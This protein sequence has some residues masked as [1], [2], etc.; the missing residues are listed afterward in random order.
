[1]YKLV[2]GCFVI[3]GAL[4]DLG[5]TPQAITSDT[6]QGQK[7]ATE[8]ARRIDQHIARGYADRKVTP[9]QPADD[10]EFL[11]RVFLD[12]TGRIPPVSE[13]HR[14]LKST[15]PNKRA[16]LIEDLLS[17]HNYSNHFAIIWRHAILPAGN[18]NQ[19][20]FLAN[21]IKSW[22]KRK[23]RD[24]IPYNRI[25]KELLT[26]N[27]ATAG[28]MVMQNG[29]G[30]DLG[31]QAYYQ[32]NEFKP[33]N[34]AASSSRLFLGVRLECA[35]C[36]DHPFARWKR[37]QFWEMAAFYVESQPNQPQQGRAMETAMLRDGKR[38]IAIPGTSKVVQAR[39]LNGMEPN[40]NSSPSSTTVLA[41]W[42]TSDSNSFFSRALVNRYWAHFFG[43]G[44]I[45][46]IDE[47]ENEDNPASHPELLQELAD[48]FVKSNYDLKFLIRA[49]VNSQTYQ[50]ASVAGR[51]EQEDPRAFARMALKGLSGEQLFD[52]LCQATGF[53]S[54][55]QSSSAGGL[56]SAR[57]D[58]LSRF[59]NSVD[60]KTEQQTSILQAL[61]LMN[62]KLVADVTS[63]ERSQTL[64]ALLDSPFLSHQQRLESLFLAALS[65]PM[66]PDEER[67]L[68]RYVDSGGPSRDSRKALAD[69]FWVLLNSSE[70]CLNH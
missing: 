27:H 23:L 39:F 35:Q 29:N 53:R 7:S 41:N 17:S 18:N 45:E 50:L 61:A 10:A 20:D 2:P 12:L 13:V 15:D 67:R 5:M 54:D 11:R 47:L 24:E 51:P 43:V 30:L 68:I 42:I 3:V 48:A 32:A 44:L 25:V 19:N 70:F 6:H 66:R 28:R 31:S 58:F 56:A 8:L 59:D 57:N 52:S 40:L 49:I 22:M 46:P 14:F 38:E 55:A 1:M 26:G 60:K 65:R 62:G 9:V 64:A 4:I 21:Q 37:N 69:V 34:L 16:Q 33:E 63:L 36:H